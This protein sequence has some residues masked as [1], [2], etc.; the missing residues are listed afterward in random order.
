MIER[1]LSQ[2][3]EE[4]VSHNAAVRKHVFLRNGEVPRITQLAQGV[5][6]P[7]ESCPAHHHEDMTEVFL[8]TSGT[9]TC[10]IDGQRQEYPSGS[11]LVVEVHESH[12]LSNET[13]EDL[14]LTYF[15]VVTEPK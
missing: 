2:V 7:G 12:E 5:F 14:H 6:P 4:P 9:L 3:D 15:G 10:T 13:S 1:S 11:C 8:V